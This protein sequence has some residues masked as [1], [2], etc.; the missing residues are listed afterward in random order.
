MMEKAELMMSNLPERSSRPVFPQFLVLLALAIGLDVGLRLVRGRPLV[1][2]EILGL[3]ASALLLHVWNRQQLRT[4]GLWLVTLGVLGLIYVAW[5]I[6]WPHAARPTSTANWIA[7]TPLFLLCF[8]IP[9]VVIVF[10]FRMARSSY[11]IAF[12]EQQ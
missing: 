6:F 9:I 11:R 2:L 5:R 7:I 4:R 1:W 8:G 12:Q 10:G 3:A